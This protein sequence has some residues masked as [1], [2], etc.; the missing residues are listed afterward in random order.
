MRALG[1]HVFAGSFSVGVQKHADVLAHL[2]YDG[3]AA[4]TAKANYDFP[5]YESKEDWPE[6]PSAEFGDVDLLFGNPPCAPFSA[7]A[8][9]NSGGVEDE[10]VRRIEEVASMADSV[11]PRV[12][13][14]ESVAQAWTKGHSLIDDIEERASDMG[15]N[16]THYL[17]DVNFHGPPQR[18]KRYLFIAHD[19]PI[20]W[21][22]PEPER[23]GIDDVAAEVFEDDPGREIA[24]L[25]DRAREA[26]EDMLPELEPGDRLREHYMEQDDPGGWTPFHTVRKMRAEGPTCAALGGVRFIHPTEDRFLTVTELSKLMG[27][28]DD[29]EFK[30]SSTTQ[31]SYYIA[32]GVAAPVGEWLARNVRQ[33]L[34]RDPE[35]TGVSVVIDAR[36]ED[37]GYRFFETD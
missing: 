5:I 32:K 8:G 31:D 6:N 2:E 10:R 7:H 28:P 14:F 13:A 16:V 18:R 34:D 11:R 15:Y 3:Y 23:T 22:L 24:P 25:R 37:F 29:F 33:H 4:G 35:Q 21:D 20:D 1:I 19:M 17:H 27:Y 12:W 26:W 36:S 30:G 9:G